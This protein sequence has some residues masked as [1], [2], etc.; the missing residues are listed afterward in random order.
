MRFSTILI[1]AFTALATAA[2]NSLEIRDQDPVADAIVF[3]VQANECHVL[4]CAK[5][6]ASVV[7]I[8]LGIE[9]GAAGVKKVLSCVEGGA[10][11]VRYG[12]KWMGKIVLMIRRFALARR[13]FPSLMRSW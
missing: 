3:A 12:E 10:S 7:C 13:A 11:A 1:S 9:A 4:K 6:V 8:G 5:V 2:P